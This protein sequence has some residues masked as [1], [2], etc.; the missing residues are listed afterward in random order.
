[1]NSI[2][3]PVILFAVTM[4]ITPGP[5]NM[6]LTASGARFGY[7]KTLPFL[8]GIVL[9][10]QTQLLLCAFGLGVLFRS[11]PQIQIFLKWAGSGYILYLGYK[12][13]FSGG[14][15]SKG[16]SQSK[17]MTFLQGALFQYLNPKAYIMS[18]TAMSVYPLQGEKFILSSFFIL[19]CFLMI[20][21]LCISLWA[22]FGT[23]LKKGLKSGRQ[24]RLV[25]LSLGLITAV[26]VVFI[27]I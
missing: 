8:V 25:N 1:M 14:D 2:F 13:A 23:V 18:L 7:R 16:G 19:F 9:G 17:P 11:Y 6:L 24:G 20:T 10:L 12:I 3:I 21:P 15:G 26:S 5:N 22:G 4:T 27:L